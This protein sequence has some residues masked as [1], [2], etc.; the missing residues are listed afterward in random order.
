[1]N[2]LSRRELDQGVSPQFLHAGASLAASVN[3]SGGGAH[4]L[5]SVA[6]DTHQMPWVSSSLGKRRQFLCWVKVEV[7]KSKL[8]PIPF[9]SVLGLSNVR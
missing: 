7:P 2:A 9:G 8:L 6:G 4:A 5:R 1:M 3:S